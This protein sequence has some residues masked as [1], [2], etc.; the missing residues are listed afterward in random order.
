LHE[1]VEALDDAAGTEIADICKKD[2]AGFTHAVAGITLT[3]YWSNFHNR[4]ILPPI[5]DP[6]TGQWPVQ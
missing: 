4:C 2:N 1:L 3:S 6:N 5:P